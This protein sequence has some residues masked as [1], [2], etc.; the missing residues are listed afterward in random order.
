MELS[1]VLGQR[2]PMCVSPPLR[3]LWLDQGPQYDENGTGC[4]RRIGTGPDEGGVSSGRGRRRHR[5]GR[6]PLDLPFVCVTSG[7]MRK[8]QRSWVKMHVLDS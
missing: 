1:C 5:G 6:Y 2:A 7:S 4:E 8:P 3:H